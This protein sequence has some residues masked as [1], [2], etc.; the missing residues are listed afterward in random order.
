M[1]VDENHLLVRL[2][3]LDSHGEE[4]VHTNERIRGADMSSA[5]FFIVLG[6]CG[7]VLPITISIR[8]SVGRAIV[9]Y[10][11]GPWFESRRMDYH[12]ILLSI[13]SAS[14]TYSKISLLSTITLQTEL[15]S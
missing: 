13:F 11:I 7:I 1:P 15:S 4:V 6:S 5:F 2:P 12:F 9:L 10:T 3:V 8:S 14:S